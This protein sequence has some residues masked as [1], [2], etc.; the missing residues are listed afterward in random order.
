[1]TTNFVDS[2]YFV[3]GVEG[4]VFSSW[5]NMTTRHMWARDSFPL[6]CVNSGVRGRFSMIGYDAK[7]LGPQ[8]SIQTAAE[9]VL[10]HIRADR[11]QVSY[12]I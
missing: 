5:V 4:D 12:R 8:K 6:H 11:P 7:V 1:M 9:E 3:H 10:N 2:A